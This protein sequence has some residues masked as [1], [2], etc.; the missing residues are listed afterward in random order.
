[1]KKRTHYIIPLLMTMVACPINM[2]AKTVETDSLS[3]PTVEVDSISFD[4]QQFE[5][6][7]LAYSLTI[8]QSEAKEEA[9]KKA[10]QVA[11]T[12]FLPAVDATG[13]YQYRINDYDMSMGSVPMALEHDSYN[14]G[15]AVMQ[16]LYKGGQL[17]YDYKGKKIQ[18]A[19][20]REELRL[21]TDNVI[22]A[23]E[24]SY[25][26]AAAQKEMY[27]VMN[28]YST[29]V[30]L[31]LNVLKDRYE[32]GMISQIDLLQMEVRKKEAEM[33]RLN[34]WESYQLAL[35][36]MNVL[37]GKTPTDSLHLAESISL[38]R[39]TPVKIELQ[40]ALLYR[41]DLSVLKLN[42]DYQHN[43]INLVTSKYNPS[44]SV[45]YQGTWGTQMINLNGDTQFN[46]TLMVSLK[47]PVFHWGARSK[48]KASQRA[49]YNQARYALQDKEDQISKELAAA[50]T[51]LTQA[52][53]RIELAEK[54]C[55]LA[56]ESLELNTFSYTEGRLSILDVLTAQLTWIQAY[57]NLVQSQYQEKIAQADYR[58][59]SGMRYQ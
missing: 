11:K 14:V 34:A 10:M 4:Y 19:I 3:W 29:I 26:G 57:T 7:V 1:M 33:Q 25:W 36:N 13:N 35:Q 18:S 8:K 53:E 44:L 41:P 39:E 2:G 46:S 24:N 37:M 51:N 12:T 59:V 5:E 49:L 52:K 48:E 54:N 45:G 42:A 23:A 16:P 27:D 9:M 43:Q 15:F 6:Q 47:I 55:K 31:L 22:Y 56:D 20:S 58:R 50:W 40:T 32:D 17:H 28:R 38:K 21:T 30:G